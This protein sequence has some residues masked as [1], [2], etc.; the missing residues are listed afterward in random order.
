MSTADRLR[1]R[2]EAGRCDTLTV[3]RI[4]PAATP[5]ASALLWAAALMVEPGPYVP[6]AV[7]L[8]GIGVIAMATVGVVGTILVGGRW[9]QRLTLSAQGVT[10]VI[11]TVRPLDIWWVIAL[12]MTVAAVVSVLVGPARTGF[13]ELPSATGPP[14]RSVLVMLM[15]LATPA[16]MGLMSYEATTAATTIVGLSG[17]LVAFWYSRVLPGGYYVLRLGWPAIAIGL[18]FAQE[19]AAAAAS[20]AW[21]TAVTVAAWHPSV[22]VA[23]YPPRQRG[24]AFPIPAELAPSEILGA[25]DVDSQGQPR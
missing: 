16:L 15:L 1:L 9:A 4:F 6:A 7:F 22:R 10:L 18:A 13:R 3:S 20:V 19:P 5:L 17:P 12:A 2:L 14:E 21:G 25:A 8:I 24:E 23:F 11:A